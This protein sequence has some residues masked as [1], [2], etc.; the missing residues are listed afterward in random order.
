MNPVHDQHDLMDG[1]RDS[2]GSG[3]GETST[4]IVGADQHRILSGQPLG[5]GDADAGASSGIPGVVLA[6]ELAPACV[7]EHGVAGLQCELLP[8][9]RLL[10][11]PAT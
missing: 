7:D 5:G 8:R 10:D 11:D 1:K 4:P 3:F 9:E 2:F 6:P